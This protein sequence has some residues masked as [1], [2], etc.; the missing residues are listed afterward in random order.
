MAPGYITCI[1]E[2]ENEFKRVFFI[3]RVT[4]LTPEVDFFPE[5]AIA[6]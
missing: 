6:F 1:K 3:A 5:Q 2:G 4:S